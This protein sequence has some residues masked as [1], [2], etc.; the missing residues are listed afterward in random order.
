M[1]ATLPANVGYWCLDICVVCVVHKRKQALLSVVAA[2]SSSI[3]VLEN[4]L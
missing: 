2:R 4:Y 1:K 3:N